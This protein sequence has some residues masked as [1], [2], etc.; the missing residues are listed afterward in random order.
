MIRRQSTFNYFY[1]LLSEEEQIQFQNPLPM[2]M[3]SDRLR[4]PKRL[5][6]YKESSK[7]GKFTVPPT[8]LDLTVSSTVKANQR[9]KIPDEQIKAL[10]ED[11]QERIKNHS[12]KLFL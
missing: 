10:P 1:R 7:T 5:K 11:L 6:S 12:M 2:L 8:L 4:L 9:G 3:Y